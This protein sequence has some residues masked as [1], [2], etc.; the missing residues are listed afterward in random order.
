[1]EADVDRGD[2][3]LFP[4]SELP[5]GLHVGKEG[6]HVEGDPGPDP[7]RLLPVGMGEGFAALEGKVVFDGGVGGPSRIAFLDLQGKE[8]GPLLGLVEDPPLARLFLAED[9]GPF[10][11]GFLA[12][13]RL[14][15]LAS[16]RGAEPQLDPLPFVG[17]AFPLPVVGK[18][19]P[20]LLLPLPE[21]R[22]GG[23]AFPR[24]AGKEEE[25]EEKDGGRRFHR[26]ILPNSA[27]FVT[28]PG[29]RKGGSPLP[30]EDPSSPRSP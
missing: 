16:L 23:R 6:I 25:R 1:M 5:E 13:E 18:G 24:P 11:G 2:P 14:R 15:V 10:D 22:P 19:R 17:E 30:P 9:P 26:T 29:I 27:G 21:G 4:G 8:G 12:I 7:F 3:F 28:T 20:E